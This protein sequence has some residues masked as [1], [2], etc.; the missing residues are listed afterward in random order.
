MGTAGMAALYGLA[1]AAIIMGFYGHLLHAIL[2]VLMAIDAPFRIRRWVRR[3]RAFGLLPN[4]VKQ[5]MVAG[6]W[7]AAF[8]VA[9]LMVA[10]LVRR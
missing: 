6:W 8:V 4:H 9:I 2:G 10:P 1:L 5:Q 7:L 3:R